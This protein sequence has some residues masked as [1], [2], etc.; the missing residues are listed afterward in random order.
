MGHD[1]WWVRWCLAPLPNSSTHVKSLELMN[2]NL[3]GKGAFTDLR[4]LK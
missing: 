3:F 1:S 4:I 2:V